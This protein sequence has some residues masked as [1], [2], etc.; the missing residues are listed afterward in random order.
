MKVGLTGSLTNV[1]SS[2]AFAAVHTPEIQQ[3]WIDEV[4][5]SKWDYSFGFY[6]AWARKSPRTRSRM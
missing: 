3:G 2:A 1:P 6:A 5:G 4:D